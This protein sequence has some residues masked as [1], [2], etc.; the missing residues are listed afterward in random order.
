MTGAVA[1]W[2]WRYH[3][4][5]YSLWDDEE[6]AAGV[7][8]AMD[9]DGGGVPAGIQFQDGRLIDRDDWDAYAAAQE[10]REQA[11]TEYLR[12]ERPPQRKITAPFGGG[13]IEIDA[14]EPSWL[15]VKS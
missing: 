14:R 4:M 1:L 3:S 9:V 11:E 6:E 15:G 8:A 2:Y 13:Q 5:D 12:Q 10:R 7:A